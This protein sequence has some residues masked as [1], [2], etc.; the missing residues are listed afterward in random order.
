MVVVF[1]GF[2]G[3]DINQTWS[4]TGTN[5]VQLHPKKAPSI[6]EGMGMAY[7]PIT[8]Q[9]VLFGGELGTVKTLFGDTWAFSGP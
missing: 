8:D 1:G 7:D 4:W 5:W 3:N 9:V 6:R 2:A